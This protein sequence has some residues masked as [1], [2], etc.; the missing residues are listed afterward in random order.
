MPSIASTQPILVTGASGFV[1]ACLCRRFAAAGHK[2]VAVL[3]TTGRSWRLADAGPNVETARADLTHADEVRALVR[4]ISPE[5]AVNC[6]V[7]G[8]YPDQIDTARIY[9]VNFDAVRMLLEALIERGNL[10]AFVQASSSSEYGFNSAAPR[11]DAP[12][13][14]DSDYAVAKVASS[15]YV[16]FLGKKKKVPAWVLRLYSVYGPY[17]D[18][19]RLIPTLL[20]HAKSGAWPKLVDPTISRDFVFVDEVC[21]AFEKVIERAGSLEPGDVFNVGSGQKSTIGDVVELVRRTFDVAAEPVWGTMPDRRWDC[22]DW[23]SDPR[24]AGE[25]LGWRA[26]VP[27]AE[28]LL[29]T[30]HWMEKNPA[31]L[32]VAKAE[33]I[34]AGGRLG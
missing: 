15:A 31:L 1:G 33:S 3:G 28:G 14:P 34:A 12:T 13:Y 27:L 6:A 5:I 9:R 16:Q 30:A 11:E 8:A 7:Y 20:S 22:R 23:Y 10:R 26:V 19:S 17:E 2:V 32:S 24:K 29:K 18:A 21:A 25:V 4:D